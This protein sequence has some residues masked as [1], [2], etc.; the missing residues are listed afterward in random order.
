[1][2]KA[3]QCPTVLSD[4]LKYTHLKEERLRGK[5]VVGK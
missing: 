3:E 5:R 4:F 2:I 1:M